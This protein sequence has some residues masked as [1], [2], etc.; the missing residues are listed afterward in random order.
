MSSA[1][2]VGKNVR[3][4]ESSP[5]FDS[6]AGVII[7]IDE[8]TFVSAGDITGNTGRVV[9][10]D[11]PWGTEEMAQNMLTSLKG[12]QYQPYKAENAIIDPSVE[13]GDGVTINGLYSGVYT[14]NIKFSRLMMMDISAPQDE[15]ID[16]E[17]PYQSSTDKKIQRQ[18]LQ[19]KA[20]FDVQAT[21]ISAK[22]SKTGGDSSSFGW[23]LTDT[24][25]TLTANN[26][27]VLKA[28]ASGLEIYGKVTADSGRIGGFDIG[29]NEIYNNLSSFGG[30]QNNGVYLGTSGIQL[31]Q[32]FRVDSG[33]NMVCS[34][35]TINGSINC[36]SLNI[37]S[38]TGCTIGGSTLS[39]ST[40][41]SC[42]SGGSL[43]NSVND[44][45]SQFK[46]VATQFLNVGNTSEA[47]GSNA[48]Y[49]CNTRFLTDVSVTVNS[50][51]NCVGTDG[52]TKSPIGSLRVATTGKSF[53]YLGHSPY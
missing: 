2:F 35:A 12:Y 18:W 48:A 49:W 13:L 27:V 40:V 41:A 36:T 16:H 39:G 46:R 3:S 43:V 30:T 24:D 37:A 50:R 9:T 34:N 31:G 53:Y 44:G 4:I 8:N 28:T 10:V 6:Y 51:V 11:N 47:G 38:N 14:Q 29:A 19:T 25:W 1:I 32:G 52:T 20:E 23:T 42:L 7:N 15:T 26:N 21:Q 22:V 33:G 5:E 45:L 17:Y